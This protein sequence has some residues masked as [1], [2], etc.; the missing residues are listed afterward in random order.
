MGGVDNKD[1]VGFLQGKAGSAAGRGDQPFEVFAQRPVFKA[2]NNH[3]CAGAAVTDVHRRGY[4]AAVVDRPCQQDAAGL[5]GAG[6]AVYAAAQRVAADS[7][8]ELLPLCGGPSQESTVVQGNG[9]KIQY[10]LFRQKNSLQ[11]HRVVGAA[12]AAEIGEDGARNALFQAGKLGFFFGCGQIALDF[13]PQ[14]SHTEEG[15]PVLGIVVRLLVGRIVAGRPHDKAEGK[16]LDLG[17]SRAQIG[18]KMQAIQ[19]FPG[20]LMVQPGRDDAA[21]YEHINRDHRIVTA[22]KVFFQP[23]RQQ[24]KRG[25]PLFAA[26]QL[27]GR[28]QQLDIGAFFDH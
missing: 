22:G 3:R 14:H 2:G 17:I 13:V 10:P 8:G 11:I 7:G 6:V 19:T 23:L 1:V 28:E 4:A 12:P 18:Q 15:A 27:F 5:I 20:G 21:I 25:R 24:Q 9:E 16:E 26:H